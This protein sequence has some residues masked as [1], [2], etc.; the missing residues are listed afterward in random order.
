MMR[1]AHASATELAKQLV[2]GRIASRALLEMYLQR[3]EVLDPQINAVVV[4]DFDRARAAADAADAMLSRGECL[5]PLHGLPVTVKESFDVAGLPT[6]WGLPAH[7]DNVA[8]RS[9][10]AVRRLQAAGA[11]VFGK[12]NVP[13]LLADWQSF[14]ALYGTTANPWDLGR[15][16]GGS[17]G[18]SAAALAAG[19]TG[20]ELGS[21]I[22]GSLRIPAH[23]CGVYS[24][25][26]T[27]GVVPSSGHWI[28]PGPRTDVSVC[29]P[30]GRSAQDLAV[31]MDII[32]GADGA[33]A[34]AWRLQLPR[35]PHADL[36]SFRVA[37]MLDAAQA[38]VDAD[39]KAAVESVARFLA[40][41]G[42]TVSF[43]AR[44]DIPLDLVARDSVL[45]IRGAQSGK[46]PLAEFE[47]LL[48]ERAALAPDDDSY[49]ARYLRGMGAS[50]RDWLQANERRYGMQ[51][52]W[53][54]FFT[55]WDVLLCPP[56][57]SV[58]F[59]HDQGPPRHVRTVEVNGRRRPV[60]EQAFWAGL[61]GIAYLPA[62]VAPAGRSRDGLPIGVQIIGPQYGDLTC[63]GLARQLE[64]SFRAFEPPPLSP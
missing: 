47:H 58:A 57:S 64:G 49:W 56:A 40:T 61:A 17:S 7:R 13:P 4:R 44:P 43:D 11:I 63:I 6:T 48:R 42:A 8:T 29:G 46:L 36:A 34:R 9:A 26:P 20:F 39:V 54:R 16:P 41:Q 23:Y 52:A 22:G 31:G 62:T 37:V 24:H 14:N 12:T 3:I 55:E 2:E 18:G 30:M 25:K 59:H 1:L 27:W 5:G 10:E 53:E 19:L 33:D 38:E 60:I 35:C 15:T 51:Q 45:L 21:D 50:H 32:A 28:A